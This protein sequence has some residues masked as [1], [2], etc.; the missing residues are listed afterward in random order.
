[1]GPLPCRYN[2][3]GSEWLSD[4]CATATV[5]ITRHIFGESCKPSHF[6]RFQ[7]C[8]S[9][10]GQFQL[11]T[12]LSKFNYRC[13]HSQ[14]PSI[15]RTAWLVMECELKIVRWW[16]LWETFV[17]GLI[18]LVK[19][20]IFQGNVELQLGYFHIVP[21]TVIVVCLTVCW[22]A[23]EVNATGVLQYGWLM[24]SSWQCPSGQPMAAQERPDL[25]QWTSLPICVVS[26]LSIPQPLVHVSNLVPVS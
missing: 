16:N 17:K 25:G 20:W 2:T 1:M 11:T 8:F 24:Q 15:M 6:A 9:W 12:A 19:E 21:L 23:I 4:V 10:C 7:F 13:G 3:Q 26:V 18:S 5:D 22:L 14:T